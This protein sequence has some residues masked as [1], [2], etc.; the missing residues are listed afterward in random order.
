MFYQMIE[1]QRNKWYAENC[2]VA[3]LISY[4]GKNNKMRDAQIDAIKTYLYLKIACK[5]KPLYELFTNGKFNSLNLDELPVPTAVRETLS[6]NPALAALYEC[7]YQKV[8]G[9]KI[10]TN[11]IEAIQD[12]P[13][14][15]NANEFFK[16]VFYGVT[17]SDYLFSLP[18][19]AGKTYLMAAFIYLDLYFAMNEPTN[20]AFAH[21]FII[22]APSGLKSS[23]VPSLKTIQNFDPSWIIAEPVASELKRKLIFEVLDENKTAKK[24]NKTRNPNAQKIANHQPFADLFGLVAITNA[25]K[26][27]LD[28]IQE[29][30]GQISLFDE[31]EDIRDKQANELRNLI[32]KLP[33]LS[34]FI[35]E[36]HHAATDEKKL[37][38]VVNKWA[39]SGTVNSVIG[40]SGTPYLQKAEQF[41]ITDESGIK[42]E[43]ISNIVYY[44]RLVDGIGNFLKKP[45]VYTSSS[46]NRLEI[47]E[48]G[49][50]QFLDDYKD[51]IYPDGTCAKLGIYCGSIETLEEQVYPLIEKIVADYGLNSAEVILKFH[52]GNKNYPIPTDSEYEFAS[53]DKPLS[54]KKIILLV[55]I[56]KEGWDCRSLTGIILSQ[57]GDC[58]TNM[59]LQTSCRCLRQ[60]EKGVIESALIYLNEGNAKTLNLQLQQQHKINLD[61]F[62]KGTQ[63]TFYPIKRYDRT[64]YL[65]LP[66][67]DFYQLKINY[68]TFNEEEPTDIADKI[69]QSPAGTEIQMLKE[70]NEMSTELRR[71]DIDIDSTERGTMIANF[72]T[73]MNEICKESFGFVGYESLT[74]YITELKKV[75][76]KI[77]FIKD[78]NYYFSSLFNQVVVREN[79]RKAFYAKR[80]FKTTEELIPDEASLLHVE[81]FTNEI[82]TSTPKIFTPDADTVEK[83][84]ADDK[85]VLG[86]SKVEKH[87]L[88]LAKATNNTEIIKLLS[89]KSF[90]HAMKNNSYHYLP[91]KTDSDFE[92]KFL[93]EILTFDVVKELNLEVYYNGDRALTEF[94]IKCY[95]SANGKLRYI[96]M[97]TPD[98][99]IIKRK[100][101]DIHKLIIVETKGKIYANDPTFVDKRQFTVND[102]ILKNNEMFGYN[103]FAYLYLE[104]SISENNRII[105]TIETV[106]EFFTEIN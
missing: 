89:N 74:P 55:Q 44:Y 41:F 3:D 102:F 48:S 57:E 79:I 10:S 35:D 104:D 72:N 66:K 30:N 12:N 86:L 63:A 28:R 50:R 49:V 100:N 69:L 25:E 19:G 59:V 87:M 60:V 62:Q 85:G 64:K 77:T 56:G 95:K 32:G 76:D 34:I 81:N 93:E 78:D 24:S 45:V 11:G 73:W 52:G 23:V 5:N 4:M 29:K 17:Y 84:I 98:F 38:A 94:K 37:R 36:V 92:I 26:V 21:N 54:K 46:N 8:A 2:S 15:I 58:S 90:S 71:I 70:K 106:K 42:T 51:K 68:C 67:V 91:Y 96:G 33:N 61:D 13:A 20:K 82:I 47:V 88:E 83:I 18:M 99:L 65:K 31:S 53:L 80:S 101:R 14:T 1:K 22:F 43:E 39:T 103:K 75:F 105:R 97:Y 40:F 16:N 6:N 7:C 9:K 27:I